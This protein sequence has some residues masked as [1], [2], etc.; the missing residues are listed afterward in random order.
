MKSK[1]YNETTYKTKIATFRKLGH[2]MVYKS[3]IHCKKGDYFHLFYSDIDTVYRACDNCYM[4]E[5]I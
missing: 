4:I 5:K 1:Q 2:S 3:C